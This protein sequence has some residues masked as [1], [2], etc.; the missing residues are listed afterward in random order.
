MQGGAVMGSI[1]G[2]V[3][4][5]L[6]TIHNR[7]IAARFLLLWTTTKGSTER[8][9]PPAAAAATGSAEEAREQGAGVAS[10]TLISPRCGWPRSKA[11]SKC[12]RCVGWLKAVGIEQPTR[13]CT[14]RD[15]EGL[16]TVRQRRRPQGPQHVA[17]FVIPFRG[18]S[19]VSLCS[20]PTPF[21]RGEHPC[22]LPHHRSRV[23]QC[24]CCPRARCCLRGSKSWFLPASPFAKERGL[25]RFCGGDWSLWRSRET[26]RRAELLVDAVRQ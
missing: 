25:V 8:A 18:P 9:S 5:P 26:P 2:V 11:S 4:A 20:P 7:T 23:P 1:A 15:R 24:S 16:A 21:S 3:H 13:R 12:K 6:C 19:S 17:F 10:S 14:S 22:F